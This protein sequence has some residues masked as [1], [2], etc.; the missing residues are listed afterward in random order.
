MTISKISRALFF[1]MIMHLSF[2]A[3]SQKWINSLKMDSVEYGPFGVGFI[4]TVIFDDDDYI[5]KGEQIK[6]PL[7][8]QIW[9]PSKQKV[10]TPM[11]FSEYTKLP[12][13]FHNK[14]LSQVF[15]KYVESTILKDLFYAPVNELTEDVIKTDTIIK[16]WERLNDSKVYAQRKLPIAKGKFPLILYRHGAQS[17]PFD[18][19]IACE[20]WASKGFIVASA[21][22][23]LPTQ[24]GLTDAPI[25]TVIIDKGDTSIYSKSTFKKDILA[26]SKFIK[27][28]DFVN[29]N[30]TVGIGH[31]MGAQRW[32]EYDVSNYPKIANTIIS[33]HTT[34]ESDS[35]A[36]LREWHNNLL[37]LTDSRAKNAVT[38]TYL[39][40]P[41]NPNWYGQNIPTT[42]T[43]S[44]PGFIP[45]RLNK[46]TPYIFVAGQYVN[47]NSFISWLP[48]QS[49]LIRFD[50]SFGFGYG[51]DF[52][53]LQWKYYRE[54]ITL[55][56]D[57]IDAE[58]NKSEFKIQEKLK[59][60]WRMELY[61]FP[62]RN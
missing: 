10:K 58:L 12:V 21:W 23:N 59:N 5:F 20:Y 1:L 33:L 26:V 52:L 44:D 36:E 53:N 60:N 14:V 17:V 22:Y 2:W 55:T 61:N 37:P 27:N 45:F 16:A 28:Q 13:T 8:I 11:S 48:W 40:A 41:K 18:N 7:W 56:S 34:A 24:Y 4:D 50:K 29:T 31:S 42:D 3:Q 57:I 38:T 35:P 30:F 54:V 9:Y 32:L 51:T 62:K 49:Y 25:Y 47:H 39:F 19:N 15:E 46:Y 43:I 6:K